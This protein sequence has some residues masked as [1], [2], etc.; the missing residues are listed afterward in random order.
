MMLERI[1]TSHMILSIPVLKLLAIS[2]QFLFQRKNKIKQAKQ[3]NKYR[4]N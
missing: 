4:L 1:L 3:K 2:S